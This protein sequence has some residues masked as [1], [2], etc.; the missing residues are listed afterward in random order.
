MIFFII[1]LMLY[2]SSQGAF[3]QDRSAVEII[4]AE[5]LRNQLAQYL[6][7]DARESGFTDGHL[8]NS[9]P[10]HWQDWT[11]EKPSVLHN[12]FGNPAKW[13]KVFTGSELQGRLQKLGLRKNQKLL[14]VGQPAAWGEEGRIAWN[15]LYW[16]AQK[17]A[18]LDGGYPAWKS[19]GLDIEKG[20][21][22]A[23][24]TGDF[25][26]SPNTSRRIQKS[27]ISQNL[28]THGHDLL[29]ARTQA[30]F[31]GEKMP[32]QKRGG[33]IPGAKLIA[34]SQLYTPTGQYISSVELKKLI[35]TIQTSPITYCTGGVRSALLAILIEARLGIKAMSYDGSLWEWSREKDLPLN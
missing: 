5:A 28:K 25:I 19:L 34:F 35:G 3:A 16:G 12:F 33:K 9:Q 14:V 17:V 8:P 23:P 11:E 10:M 20:D 1:N 13:G 6:V 2:L 29:D 27:D 18:L 31:A 30:E 32:G 22:K 7:I 26:V 21:A 4:S 24:P 15:L